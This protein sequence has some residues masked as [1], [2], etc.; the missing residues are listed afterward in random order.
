MAG[1]NQGAHNKQEGQGKGK[2]E[3]HMKNAGRAAPSKQP[4]SVE[5]ICCCFM[6]IG[7]RRSGDTLVAVGR[8]WASKILSII[9]FLGMLGGGTV[10]TLWLACQIGSLMV[11]G[12]LG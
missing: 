8:R 10:C 3:R 11:L 5:G 9:T 4:R 7:G 6:R 12:R 1:T 2:W